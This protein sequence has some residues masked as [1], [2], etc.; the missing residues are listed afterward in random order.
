MSL[1]DMRS[2]GF[3]DRQ[4]LKKTKV[5][6]VTDAG[7]FLEKHILAQLLASPDI[8]KLHCLA[9]RDKPAGTPVRADC[10]IAKDHHT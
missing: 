8:D 7:G 6:L 4:L 5:V 9:L 1:P 2:S 3:I 10:L